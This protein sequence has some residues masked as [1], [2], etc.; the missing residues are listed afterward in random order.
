MT[1]TNKA[2][3]RSKVGDRRRTTTFS[4]RANQGLL[5]TIKKHCEACGHH[6]FWIKN[7]NLVCTKCGYRIH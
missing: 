1:E 7:K 4:K 3:G 6:K 2:T 5:G